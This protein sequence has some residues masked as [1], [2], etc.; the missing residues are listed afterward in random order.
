MLFNSYLF[1]FAFLPV[2]YVGYYALARIGWVW[3]K[4]WLAAASLV[5]YSA[6]DLRFLPI[7]L[8]SILFNYAV[9]YQIAKSAERGAK[10]RARA[11][12]VLGIVGDLGALA[13]FKYVNF[14]LATVNLV[15]GTTWSLGEILL[16][17]GISFFTFTQ[18]AYLVDAYQGKAREYRFADYALFVTYFPHLIVGPIL[19]HAQMMPQFNQAATFVQDRLRFAVGIAIFTV[20]LFKKVAL[21]DRIAI[22]ADTVFNAAAQGAPLT[23]SEAWAGTLAYTLQLYFDFSGYSDMAVGLSLLFGIRMPLNFAAPLQSTS[24]IEMW[25]RWHMT[26]G[27]FL[28][29]YLY[30]PIA[31]FGKNA[32]KAAVGLI[33]TMF[34]GG[35]WHGAGWTFVVFGLLHGAYLVTNHFWHLWVMRKVRLSRPSAFVYDRTCHLLTFFAWMMGL[36]IFRSNTM[37]TATHVFS[38]MFGGGAVAESAFPHFDLNW[39]Q[40]IAWL[41]ALL[42]IAWFGPSMI[43][44]FRPY[45]PALATMRFDEP[46]TRFEWR[47]DWRWAIGLGLLLAAS[48]MMMSRTSVF[49]YFQF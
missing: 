35:L 11:W 24:M 18:I 40:G 17:L 16:P 30:Q 28:R 5:F 36:V 26:L 37:T 9:G 19:H 33:V 31:G 12:L 49:L 2:T 42:A 29:D 21:A 7:L 39:H 23:A 15:V 10:Q 46:P 1:L 34:L 6:W 41:A 25:Q 47:P 4:V 8:A 22:Y 43:R 45:K 20:G 48:I 14:F 27:R 44:M 38:A 3:A 32:G 13:Y